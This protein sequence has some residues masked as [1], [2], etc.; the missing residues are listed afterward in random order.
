VSPTDAVPGRPATESAMRLGET[1]M[2]PV[3]LAYDS[4]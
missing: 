1:A 2:N 3:G 4:A